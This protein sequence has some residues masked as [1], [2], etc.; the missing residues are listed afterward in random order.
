M[1]E[2]AEGNIIELKPF[3]VFVSTFTPNQGTPVFEDMRY[4][5]E[6]IQ[7]VETQSSAQFSNHTAIFSAPSKG[8]YTLEVT[9]RSEIFD[10]EKW[11]AHT[12]SVTQQK[13][14]T[15]RETADVPPGNDKPERENPGNESPNGKPSHPDRTA[16]ESKKDGTQG[17]P[18]T[19]EFN[20]IRQ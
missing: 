20:R 5:P 9:Y 18:K 17:L 3:T 4:F 11:S 2:N 6:K 14:I 7:I 15:V 12:E 13:A 8:E 1:A 10:G 19:G 16:K